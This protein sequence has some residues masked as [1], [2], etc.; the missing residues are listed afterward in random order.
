MDLKSWRVP[1]A[2]APTAT[3]VTGVALVVAYPLVS[4][5]LRSVLYGGVAVAAALAMVAVA[6]RGRG[7]S[8]TAWRLLSAGVVT[9]VVGDLADQLL[10]SAGPVGTPSAADFLF[11]AG[12]A[13]IW[14]ALAMLLLR[15]GSMVVTLLDTFVI[16]TA[17]ATVLWSVVVHRMVGDPS[18]PLA[19]FVTIAAYPLVDVAMLG[20]VAAAVLG[21][22]RPDR[23][24]W[25][26]AT[27]AGVSLARDLAYTITRLSGSGDTV[28]AESAFL[29]AYVLWVTAALSPSTAPGE[30]RVHRLDWST[31]RLRLFVAAACTPVAMAAYETVAYG[32]LDT[33]AVA[34]TSLVICLAV[35]ARL[36]IVVRD[37]RDLI[38]ERSRMQVTLHRQ[39]R[40]DALT[41]L[42]NRPALVERLGQ[43]LAGDGRRPALM[44]V[45]LDDFKAVNDSLGHPTGDRLLSAIGH[46]L[47]ASVRGGDMVARLG[48]DEFA[49]V[50]QDAT[51]TSVVHLAERILAALRSPV[52]TDAGDVT[53]S[54]SIGIAI[55]VPGVTDPQTLL[56]EADVA[57]YHAKAAGRDRCALLDPAEQAA[58][59]RSLSV[60]SELARAV[61]EQEFELRYQPI[62]SLATGRIESFEALIR[63]NHPVLG[64]LSPSEFIH[65]AEH[66]AQMPAM[67]SS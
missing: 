3:L 25:M 65:A 56:R 5:D 27:A 2:S 63:W 20:V 61:G 55:A 8:R 53:V 44:I 1:S 11:L 54:G 49:V 9:L 23:R 34:L 33:I 52:S 32:R 50:V 62:V 14:I 31:A 58:A 22:R 67:R 40:L 21:G 66:S 46:R 47:A 43:M 36:H 17:A 64:L 45:D 35:I 26:L 12:T 39:A 19:E 24:L 29:L 48:G 18:V 57:L 10:A 13:A 37:Q 60:P 51:P 28:L 38:D 59:L 41:E 15:R 16:A 4:E 6:I 42:P 7:L 30:S